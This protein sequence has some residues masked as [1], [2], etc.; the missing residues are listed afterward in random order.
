LLQIFQ[1]STLLESQ[2]QS[3]ELVLPGAP[4]QRIHA[5][6]EFDKKFGLINAFVGLRQYKLGWQ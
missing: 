1:G 5:C 2:M 6:Q 4:A 3:V